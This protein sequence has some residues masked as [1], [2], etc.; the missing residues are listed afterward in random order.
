MVSIIWDGALLH[1]KFVVIARRNPA[2]VPTLEAYAGSANFTFAAM[3][4][5]FGEHPQRLQGL[6]DPQALLH[7]TL[8]LLKDIYPGVVDFL[9]KKKKAKR[10]RY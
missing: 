7:L 9:V 2:N 10:A 5:N 4:K 3:N 6:Q 8:L 1:T